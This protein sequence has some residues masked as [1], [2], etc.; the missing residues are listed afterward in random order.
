MIL[1]QFFW[2]AMHACLGGNMFAV[3]HAIGKAYNLVFARVKW[4]M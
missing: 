4:S 3:D 1:V 2:S